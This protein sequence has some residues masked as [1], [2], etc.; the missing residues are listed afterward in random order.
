MR[1]PAAPTIIAILLGF[2]V[3]IVISNYFFGRE[4]HE[5]NPH[6]DDV[7]RKEEVLGLHGEDESDREEE[8]VSRRG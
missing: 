1:H 2:L 7:P 5:G 4:H 3:L 8:A 6:P